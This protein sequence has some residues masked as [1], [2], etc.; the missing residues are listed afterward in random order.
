MFAVGKQVH[1]VLPAASILL[2]QDVPPGRHGLQIV[3]REDA[4]DLFVRI[5]VIW[6][7]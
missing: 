1:F 3:G 4:V 2:G 5:Q 6:K 7:G